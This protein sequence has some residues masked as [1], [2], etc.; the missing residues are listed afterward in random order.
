MP[1]KD[2][3]DQKRATQTYVSRLKKLVYDS[4]GNKCNC[5]GETGKSF[6]QIDHVNNDGNL[7]RRNRK[8]KGYSSNI[9]YLDIIRQNFPN[10]Y[11]ILCANCNWSKRVNKGSCEHILIIGG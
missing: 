10:R 8:N 5:C 11:Q 7:H 3:R 1:Y 6:L 2:K 4:Y 9:L